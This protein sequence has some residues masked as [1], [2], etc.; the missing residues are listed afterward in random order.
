MT[1]NVLVFGATSAIA[2]AIAR[3]YAARAASLVLV[4]RDRARLEANAADL[5]VRGAAKTVVIQADLA[6]LA[7]HRELVDRAAAELGT[8]DVAIIAHGTLPDQ[9]ECEENS[10]ALSRALDT[11][12]SSVVSLAAVLAARLERERHGTIAVFGSV[13]GDRGRRGNYTYGAAKA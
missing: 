4:G 5:L 9:R 10:D 13:A 6:E 2:H 11:N 12:F 3:L 7:T 1:Q 8:L